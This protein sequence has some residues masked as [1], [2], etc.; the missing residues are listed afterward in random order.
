MP[1]DL[2]NPSPC[3]SNAICKELNGAG[4]CTC[5]SNYIGNPYEGCRPECLLNS[6]CSANQACMNSKCQD[7]CPGICGRNAECHVINHLPVCECY[8][9]HTGNAFVLCSLMLP[10]IFYKTILWK[11][12]I[13][14]KDFLKKII[15]Y[16]LTEVDQTISR[17]CNPSPCGP[18]SQ[19]RSING[20]SVCS[21]LPDFIGSPPSCRPECTISTECAPNLACIN[22][23]C[24]DPCPGS[25]GSNTRCETINHKAICACQPSFTGDPLVACFEMMSKFLKIHKCIYKK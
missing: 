7:P 1:I 15:K 3:G 11:K 22:K 17:P 19:C 12:N 2:C 8:P 25:C 6:D 18:N 5:I 4:S 20:Q 13:V 21:C 23:K 16:S 14:K 9:G 24:G 10:G